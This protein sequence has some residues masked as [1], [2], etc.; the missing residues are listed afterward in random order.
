[1]QDIKTFLNGTTPQQ[2]LTWMLVILGWVVSVFAG[3]RFLLRNARNSW[4]G[5]IKKAISTLEDDAI[6]FWM[7]ENNK[8]EILEL[9]KLT[10]SIKDI[11]QLAKEIEK[12]KG[13]KYNNANFISLRR[14]I[15]TEAYNDDKT[16]QRKLSVGDFRIKEIQEE[17][18]NLKNYYT[19]K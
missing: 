5:D 10:R 7:G 17:C 6:D 12:Y 2:W 18:A 11:T 3:W 15:T 4:I 16:L 8:N 19:R 1:M 9:G 14:A 13:Q